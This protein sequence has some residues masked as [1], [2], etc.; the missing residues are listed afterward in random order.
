MYILG[1]ESTTERLFTA[2]SFKGK[3]LSQMEVKNSRKHMVGIIGVV[4]KVLKDSGISLES[5]NVFAANIG[6]GDFTGTRIGLSIIKTFSWVKSRKSCGVSALD[7]YA[8]RALFKN[9]KDIEARLK[10][11]ED[12]AIC[13]I[14]DVRNKE[15][16]FSFYKLFKE[17]DQKKNKVVCCL[18][19]GG[20]RYFLK[21]TGQN[22]LVKAFEMKESFLPLIEGHCYYICGNSFLNYKD[23]LRDI[24]KSTRRLILDKG[25][26][27]PDAASLNKAAFFK[28]AREEEKNLVPVY[29]REFVPFG[30]KD[31]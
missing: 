25:V 14:L 17:Q 23:L 24:G 18:E 19:V 21:K 20:H 30:G 4:D 28:A 3:L 29:I 22:H 27:Y 5:I 12:V 16:Y 11:G 9:I 8:V 10:K 13:P 6:P 15:L 1:I 2:V 31:G 26:A 7:V